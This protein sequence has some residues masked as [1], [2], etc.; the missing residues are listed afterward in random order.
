MDVVVLVSSGLSLLL[1]ILIHF[2]VFQTLDKHGVVK[3]IL[4]TYIIGNIVS[5]LVNFALFKM[6]SIAR[7]ISVVLWFVSFLLFNLL[8]VSYILGFFGMMVASLRVRMLREIY[9]AGD[10]GISQSELMQKYNEKIIVDE[11]LR[12]L[13]SSADV[14]KRG[15]NYILVNRFSVF[16]IHHNLYKTFKKLYT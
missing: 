1:F 7:E 2:L 11:R 13:Q 3:G 5:L 10:R 12:R 15:G 14:V 16:R 8:A 6:L 9:F 4:Y